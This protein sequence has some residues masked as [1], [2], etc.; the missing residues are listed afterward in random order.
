[1]HPKFQSLDHCYRDQASKSY[2]YSK[3]IW[4][5]LKMA[6]AIVMSFKYSSTRLHY[7]RIN[8]DNL[9]IR[10]WGESIGVGFRLLSKN[11]FLDFFD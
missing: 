3:F 7:L 4:G 2:S 5:I 6:T 8:F 10:N 11:F 9:Y 1:M